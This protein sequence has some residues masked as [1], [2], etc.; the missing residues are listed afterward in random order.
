MIG[1]TNDFAEVV[2][3]HGHACPGL[4]FGFRVSLLA[5]QELGLERSADEGLVAI[6]ENNSCAVDAIQS[7]TG[8]T[9]GK[10]NLV[11][12]DY[13]KQVYTFLKRSTGD[14][15][16]IAVDW[17]P[18]PEGPDEER[19]WEKYSAGDRSETVVQAIRS[20]KSIKLKAIMAATDSELF[21]VSRP[22]VSLP[23]T[24]QIFK[25]LRCNRCGEK[26]MEPRIIGGGADS[27]CVPCSEAK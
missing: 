19:S 5:L 13:G 10:G 6:V 3:F 16:R 9:F 18:P 22:Q 27:I 15:V 7:M 1:S 4:A 12:R 11:F 14:A 24:A 8:C 23:P 21:T 25:S 26:V 2:R 17:E 20:R